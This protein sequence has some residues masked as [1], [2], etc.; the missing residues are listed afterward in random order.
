MS[1]IGYPIIWAL[2]VILI[3]TEVLYRLPVGTIADDDDEEE[4]ND[5]KIMVEETPVT[6][7]SVTGNDITMLILMY[8]LHGGMDLYSQFKEI[9]AD[10]R[11]KYPGLME[12][13]DALIKAKKDLKN[14]IQKIE[15]TR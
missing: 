13:H 10:T 4:P 7:R 14:E 11:K 3:C 9:E 12:A 8:R 15:S 6:P 5:N 1:Y 2:V